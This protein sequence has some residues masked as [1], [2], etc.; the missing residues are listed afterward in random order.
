MDAEIAVTVFAIASARTVRRKFAFAAR[1]VVMCMLLVR[2][3]GNRGW[4][5]RMFMGAVRGFE[6]AGS[7]G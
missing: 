5:G 2:R 4:R 6:T 7:P 1:V 3:L